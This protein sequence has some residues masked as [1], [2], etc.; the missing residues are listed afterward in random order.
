VVDSVRKRAR[1]YMCTENPGIN[2]V[3]LSLCLFL[4]SQKLDLSMDCSITLRVFRLERIE[5]DYHAV[6]LAYD[7]WRDELQH[8]ITPFN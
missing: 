4:L 3:F 7:K 8:S 6:K 5:R 1:V 2:D